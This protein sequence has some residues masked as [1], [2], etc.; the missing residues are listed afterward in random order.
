MAKNE[1][2]KVANKSTKSTKNKV[3][4]ENLSSSLKNTKAESAPQN[5]EVEEINSKPVFKAPVKKSNTRRNVTIG[6]AAALLVATAV[7]VPT[8]IYLNRDKGFTVTIDYGRQDMANQTIEVEK[9][10]KVGDIV[11]PEIPG[12]Y[13]AGFYGDETYGNELDPNT[14][15]NSDTTIYL[16][17]IQIHY[18]FAML[19]AGV[20]VKNSEGELID[21]N[22][23]T[24]S[25]V[26]GEEVEIS[27]TLE[28]SKEL[29]EFTALGLEV[30]ENFT[31]TQLT[32][33]TASSIFTGKFKITGQG[34][35]T[36]QETE[37]P[38]IYTTTDSILTYETS[39]SYDGFTVTG[40]AT[41]KDVADLIIPSTHHGQ[42]VVEIGAGA[43]GSYRIP[44]NTTLTS[45]EIPNTIKSIDNAAFCN[46][47]NMSSVT[48]PNSVTNIGE[49]AFAGTSLTSIIIP[50]SVISLGYEAFCATDLISVTI[51]SNVKDM[52]NG[53]FASC[54]KLLSV[55]IENGIIEILESTFQDCT[56]LTTITIPDSVESIESLAFYNCT[57]LTSVTIGSGVTSIGESAF[58]N[59]SA[60]SEVIID[61]ADVYNAVSSS[62]SS[63]GYLT[64]YIGAGETIKVLKTVVDEN[65]TNTYLNSSF[66][67]TDGE[68]DFVDYYVFTRN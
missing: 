8:A 29:D 62:T 66:T 59:C 18:S 67:R 65:D 27:Y 16:H 60:L 31:A 1:K 38:I 6:V 35:T 25:F 10:S 24:N 54:K 42:P 51:P 40:F 64:R 37:L 30:V 15:I 9:G 17:Y 45:V 41:G 22:S 33:G 50:N 57:S 7:V 46:C 52:D 58:Y 68:G 55:T 19:P 61:S 5:E 48:I 56:S 36:A 11:A 28:A 63:N 39:T 47:V 43:F 20:T 14:E 26:Y 49:S 2:E 34:L 32:D 13:F 21:T 3:G 12:Y 23:A 53:I 44:S 4:G